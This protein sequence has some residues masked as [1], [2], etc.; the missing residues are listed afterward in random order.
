[1][2]QR[3]INELTA[4]E[5]EAL[6]R[7]L[8]PGAR[9]E[10]LRRRCRTDYVRFARSC[11]PELCTLPWS[12]MHRHLFRR[13]AAKTA[14]E[15]AE[16]SGVFDVVVA[17][18]GA[19]KSTLVSQV[20]PIHAM[21][22]GL[23][24]Y[25]I[26][27]SATL[28]QATQRV[29]NI[30]ATLR[31]NE[32]LRA[33]YGRERLDTLRGSSRSIELNGVRLEAYS[34]G[35]ELRGIN[36]G[37]WRPTWIVLDDVERSD[38][39]RQARHREALYDWL[40]EVVEN[41]GAGYTNIDVIGTL[42]HEDALPAR[43]ARRPDVVERTFRS[44]ISEPDDAALWAEWRERFHNLDDE[45]RLAT[46]RAYFEQRSKAML[47]GTKV[48]WPQKED[49]YEL[50]VMRETRGRAAFD[51]EKQNAPW[52]E[53]A[54]VFHASRW[55]TFKIREGRCWRE[56]A[57]GEAPSAAI[58]DLRVFG[59]LDPALGR[60]GGDWAAIAVVG[61]DRAGFCYALDL[62]LEHAPPSRQILAAFDLHERWGFTAFG[63]ETNAFQSLMLEP[64][65]AE[66]EAR[67]RRGRRWDLPLAE[68]RHGG[69]K[70][71]RILT[72]EPLIANGWLLF[73]ETLPAE[74]TAQMEAFPG[75]AHDDAPDALAA[76]VTLARNHGAGAALAT[77]GKSAKKSMK[78]Y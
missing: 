76:A 39:V 44:I 64:F 60:S 1:M 65:E 56:A 40:T 17:P 34:A 3:T 52:S 20:F 27:V 53:D 2:T 74:F 58:S 46:A 57:G 28:R 42:L 70:N 11:F 18:R 48:L 23:E 51:K 71:E 61:V 67:R 77:T 21:L 35:T 10:A 66:R 30:R 19:A 47:A 13:Q 41:L 45:D 22:Y 49:Y 55:R 5:F 31:T 8:S 54:S 12:A 24:G 63:V 7:T 43:L 38:R 14:G 25:I 69:R 15:L 36:H 73:N 29:D 32:A 59:F 16:R 33:L 78:N 75:S 68:R 6:F 37:P 4:R 9:R 50:A 26:L 72:L 62:W